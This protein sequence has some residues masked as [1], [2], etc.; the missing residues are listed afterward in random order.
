VQREI[1]LLAAAESRQYQGCGDQKYVRV[2]VL[3]GPAEAVSR[4]ALIDVLCV[5]AVAAATQNQGPS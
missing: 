5:S 2:R 1:E 3:R 4:S